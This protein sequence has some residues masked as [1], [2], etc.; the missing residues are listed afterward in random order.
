MSKIYTKFGDE[1]NTH[2]CGGE[3]IS[4]TDILV[5]LYGTID[6]LNC[7]LGLA[8]EA[9]R[10]K[11]ELKETLQQIHVIQ[12]ELLALSPVFTEAPQ[13]KFENSVVRLEYEIDVVNAKL[14]QLNSFIIPGGNELAARLHIAR[15]VCRR[16]ERVLFHFIAV[17][18]NNQNAKIIAKYLNRLS[19]WLFVMAR[20]FVN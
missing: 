1:G 2:I 12:K 19:D 3:V 20:L 9:M 15:A 10:I 13:I 16:A 11:D 5:E 8:A 7:F 18:Q 14:P 4:K 17:K 6:E